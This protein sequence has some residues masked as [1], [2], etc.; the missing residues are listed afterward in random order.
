M[1]NQGFT[2]DIKILSFGLLIFY[3]TLREEL[4][5]SQHFWIPLSQWYEHPRVLSILIVIWASPSHIT[6]AI[7][8]RVRVTGDAHITRVLGMGMPK[9]RG[10]PYHYDIGTLKTGRKLRRVS[11]RKDFWDC[12]L[13]QR[14]R[15]DNRGLEQKRF[16]ATHVHRKFTFNIPEQ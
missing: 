8:V 6:L 15:L 13:G 1:F 5:N 3:G 12:Y 4:G 10:C 2:T 14:K 11:L 16:W 9:T 7:W